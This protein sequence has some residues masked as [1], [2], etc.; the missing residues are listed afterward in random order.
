MYTCKEVRARATE[1]EVTPTHVSALR[2]AWRVSTGKR[3]VFSDDENR[4]L[5][6][7]LRKHRDEHDLTGAQVGRLLGIKQQNAARL[8]S[9]APAH[10]L[11]GM[12]RDTANNLARIL[13][14]RDAEHFLIEH[15]VLA[16]MQPLPTGTGWGDR[17]TA[18]KV[19]RKMGYA[20]EAIQ[21]VLARFRA[22]DYRAKTMRWWNDQIVLE[23]M[24]RAA[25]EPDAASASVHPIP[26]A[27]PKAKKRRSGT[28]G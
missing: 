23:A 27:T 9:D 25:A 5:R 2:N 4:A 7:A 18:V 15:G 11:T 24:A 22:P 16:E 28:H 14:F 3:Q 13:G 21:A 17:D 1:A 8:L 26:R 20:E 10:R 19:A 12:G 6:E